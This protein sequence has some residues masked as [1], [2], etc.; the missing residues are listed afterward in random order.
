VLRPDEH[1]WCTGSW[2]GVVSLEHRPGGRRIRRKV[3]GQIKTEVRDKL[4]DLHTDIEAGL[5]KPQAATV[6]APTLTVI[7]GHGRS[8]TG[9]EL[10][11]TL[12]SVLR[13]PLRSSNLLSSAS[14]PNLRKPR[15]SVSTGRR[16]DSPLVSFVV[17]VPSVGRRLSAVYGA[18][19]SQVTGMFDGPEA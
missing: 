8:W 12:E 17:S 9:A 7:L 15:S 13:Q 19:F 4:R 10:G 3:P 6:R 18:L 5:R 1:R 2:R 11:L 14:L 16:F